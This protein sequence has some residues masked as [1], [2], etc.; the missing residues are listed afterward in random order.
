MSRCL[1]IFRKKL[2]VNSSQSAE[3]LEDA[4]SDLSLGFPSESPNTD[5]PP[6]NDSHPSKVA[7]T[8]SESNEI[9]GA[10]LDSNDPDSP[11][12]SARL[13]TD[14]NSF[15]V[16]FSFARSQGGVSDATR[17]NCN[18][19]TAGATTGALMLNMQPAT[20]PRTI[21]H[22][23]PYTTTTGS[24]D[25]SSNFHNYIRGGAASASSGCQ[26]LPESSV[27]ASPTLLQQREA[28]CSF[29]MKDLE[30]RPIE[31]LIEK[32][33]HFHV[34]GSRFDSNGGQL[35]NLLQQLLKPPR[36]PLGSVTSISR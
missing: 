6:S 31:E 16:G 20:A 8:P 30:P 13:S 35:N 3:V 19:R 12:T 17:D 25:V 22:Q 29:N 24:H 4:A 23:A 9:G 7:S 21:E 10:T 2:K 33:Q 1:N 32:P 15:N 27:G 11:S 18:V 26:W 5:F 36:K 28:I 14:L 34:P